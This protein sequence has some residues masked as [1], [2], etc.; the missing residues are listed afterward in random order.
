M[1]TFRQKK[2]MDEAIELYK[3]L[4]SLDLTPNII[5]FN[6]LLAGCNEN[7][8]WLDGL[9]LS[10]KLLESGLSMEPVTF[11]LVLHF[12]A[13]SGNIEQMVNTWNSVCSNPKQRHLLEYVEAWNIFI[14]GLG[15]H[16]LAKEA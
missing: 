15:R 8:M 11:G 9:L 16:G 10:Q 2:L 5:I 7:S 12:M 3:I 1:Q 13:K 4:P 6:L 14:G